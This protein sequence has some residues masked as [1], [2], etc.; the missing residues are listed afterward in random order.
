[1]GTAERRERE[2]E[3]VR[4][5][6]LEAARDILSEHGLAALS[7]RGIA[8]RIE[9]SP[10]TIYL[11]FRDKDELI[12]EVVKEG[13]ER[14]RDCVQLELSG[15]P[16]TATA[17]EQY[18]TIGRA[19]VRFALANTAY[20]RVM[21]ELPGSARFECPDAGQVDD[22]GPGV[23]EEVVETI[24][25]ATSEGSF[26]VENARRAALI[27]WGMVHGLVSLYI[28]RH[29]MAEIGSNEEFLGL[30]DEAMR[31]IYTGWRPDA[32]RD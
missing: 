5:L 12:V 21:F 20:F 32:E 13:F 15:L 28:G 31:S 9:Y 26:G 14:L 11:Y 1:M 22:A 24:Q 4:T 6:I 27:G 17:A 23:F 8:E 18:G 19:Y 7:M 29:M 10:G 16:E 30:V 3:H 2:R 25:R